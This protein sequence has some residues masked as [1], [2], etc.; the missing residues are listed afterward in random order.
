MSGF[1]ASA[2]SRLIQARLAS[3]SSVVDSGM[4]RSVVSLWAKLRL[5]A[6]V[7]PRQV[8]RRIDQLARFAFRG[9]GRPAS[10][11]TPDFFFGL[12]G[13]HPS[14]EVYTGLGEFLSRFVRPLLSAQFFFGSF[15]HRTFGNAFLRLGYSR[16]VD[17]G[18]P[19]TTSRS[20]GDI[21]SSGR[22]A[23]RDIFAV[24]HPERSVAHFPT[25]IADC[26]F[27]K[28]KMA[29]EV[30]SMRQHHEVACFISATQTFGNDV[31]DFPARF[32]QP[33]NQSVRNDGLVNTQILI[34]GELHDSI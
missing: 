5:S 1:R 14:R 27:D 10:V 21:V 16:F 23:I 33:S 18:Q 2:F 12:S 6:L 34:F 22:H 7:P 9:N 15:G 29:D 31:V 26:D 30:F 19:G 20:F 28:Q 11:C 24:R 3:P 4:D 25:A 13:M 17:V 32:V 8:G